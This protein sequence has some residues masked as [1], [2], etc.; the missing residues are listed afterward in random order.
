MKFST[1]FCYATRGSTKGCNPKEGNPFG[2]FWDTFKVDFVGS[3]FYGP[4]HYEVYHSDMTYMWR[5]KYP[6]A[7][8]PVLAFTGAPASFPV[9]LENKHL[10]KYLQW[11]DKIT[12]MAKNFIKK[13]LPPGAFI[14]IHL[15]NGIDWVKNYKKF[16]Q[17][18]FNKFKN[19]NFY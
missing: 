16:L 19:L 6:S 11:N 12:N 10:Q 8:W 3:E 2:P 14:G 17:N 4:L 5:K 13:T 9:Q 18:T 7:K 15:R 1:A